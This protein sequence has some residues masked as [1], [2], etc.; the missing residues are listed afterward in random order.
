MNRSQMTFFVSF[1]E[2]INSLPKKDQLP[3]FRAVV[4]YGL[5]GE[6]SENLTSTQS[7]LFSLIHPVLDKSRKKA[8]NR[9]QNENKTESNEEQTDNEGD[10]EKDKEKDKQQTGNGI[11]FHGKP[12]TAFWDAYPSKIDREGAWNAWRSLA[13]SRETANKILAALDGWKKSARWTDSDGRYIPSAANFI[14]KG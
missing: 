5:F 3:L 6:H 14:S 2:A 12:F 13:P 9:K 11:A 8:S 1:W 4:S 10:K 7:A